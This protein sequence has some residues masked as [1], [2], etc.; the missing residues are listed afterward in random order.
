MRSSGWNGPLLESIY[1]PLSDTSTVANS[2]VTQNPSRGILSVMGMVQQSSSPASLRSREHS[3]PLTDR[4]VRHHGQRFRRYG[5]YF[6]DFFL[7][8]VRACTII[9]QSSGRSLW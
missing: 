8:N 7:D 3:N 6:T 2:D 4:R 9:T 5:L 1:L